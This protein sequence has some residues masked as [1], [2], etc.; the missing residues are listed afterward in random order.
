MSVPADGGSPAREHPPPV[1][2]R[3]RIRLLLGVVGVAVLLV[4]GA[5]VLFLERQRAYDRN[6]QR[7]PGAFP[8][9]SARPARVPGRAQNWLLVGSD[10]RAD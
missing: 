5:G 4:G 9:E 2:R 7:I 6:I 1:R 10:R 8:A 3:P